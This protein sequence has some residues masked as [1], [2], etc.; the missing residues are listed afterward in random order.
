MEKPFLLLALLFLTCNYFQN[1]FLNNFNIPT[2]S[3]SS[4]DEE[5]IVWDTISYSKKTHGWEAGDQVPDVKL[6]DVNNEAFL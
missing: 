1:T 5:N 6:R 3:Q 2:L 4:S